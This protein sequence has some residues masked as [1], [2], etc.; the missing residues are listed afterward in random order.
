MK[1]PIFSGVGTALI[2]PFSKGEVDFFAFSK[3]IEYQIANGA[4]ALIA[5]GT[6][7]ETP[8]LSAAERLACITFVCEQV[9]H[10][11]PVIAGCGCNDTKKTIEASKEALSAG[12]D[13][14]LLVTPYYNRP[15]E[16]GMISHFFTIADA[17]EKPILLYNVPARTGVDLSAHAC[18]ALSCHENI[19]GIKEASG[20]VAKAEKILSH[21]GHDFSLYCGDDAL[22]LPMMALGAQGVISVCSNLIPAQMH[23]LCASCLQGDLIQARTQSRALMPLWEALASE[24]NPVPIKAAMELAGRCRATVRSPLCEAQEETKGRLSAV[25]DRYL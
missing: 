20:N 22:T 11:I 25:L 12:A 8:T 23:A 21:C 15:S 14:L 18:A 19:A 24:V 7:A 5:C 6:T 2:T 4:D 10:R 1:K 16:D 13:A 9:A 17:V 3:L